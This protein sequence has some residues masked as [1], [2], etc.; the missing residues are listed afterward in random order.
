MDSNRKPQ[1]RFVQQFSAPLLKLCAAHDRLPE[2]QCASHPLDD[3][4]K[5]LLMPNADAPAEHGL[6][7]SHNI[8]ICLRVPGNR[9]HRESSGRSSL[10]TEIDSPSASAEL[11]GAAPEEALP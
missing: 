7:T 6:T 3:E 9:R 5:N 11:D 10:R 2:S 1:P 8:R 4:S